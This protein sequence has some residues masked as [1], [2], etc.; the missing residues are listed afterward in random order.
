MKAIVFTEWGPP[1]VLQLK[2]VEKPAPKD[3]E[4]L[5]KIYATAVTSGDYRARNLDVPTRIMGLFFGFYFGLRKPNVSILGNNLAGEIEA[6]GKDVKL[7]KQG[8][9][10][11]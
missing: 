8:D 1:E 4:V 10:V 3:D 11:F 6:V 5:I 7:F 9:Q 2:E